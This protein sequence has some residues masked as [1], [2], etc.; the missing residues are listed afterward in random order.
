MAGYGYRGLRGIGSK[1]YDPVLL[2]RLT[3][4][5]ET[6]RGLEAGITLGM[7]AAREAH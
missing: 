1:S 2:A 4:R 7:G 3:Q 6:T 5:F